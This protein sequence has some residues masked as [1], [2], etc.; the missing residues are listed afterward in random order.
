MKAEVGD[1]VA[2]RL[3]IWAVLN[4]TI[5]ATAITTD[6]K[7]ATTTVIK[8]AT[9]AGIKPARLSWDGLFTAETDN[10][11]YQCL[12]IVGVFLSLRD[13]R[14][15]GQDSM[16]KPTTTEKV[17]VEVGESANLPCLGDFRKTV[18]YW[19]YKHGGDTLKGR[20]QV[21]LVSPSLFILSIKDV[22]SSDAG[23]FT[24]S[25]QSGNDTLTLVVIEPSVP[26][27][28]RVKSVTSREVVL[29]WSAPKNNTEVKGYTIHI[30]EMTETGERGSRD[31]QIDEVSPSKKE[32]FT[33][34]GLK[35]SAE[36]EIR[37][38]AK[39]PNGVDTEQRLKNG[40]KSSCV[41]VKMKDI[42]LSDLKIQAVEAR[43]GQDN[44]I[45]IS[46]ILPFPRPAKLLGFN[47][48]FRSLRNGKSHTGEVNITSA[49]DE[50]DTESSWQAVL[51]D[52]KP[53]IK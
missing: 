34:K 25:T 31:I 14:A 51:E 41:T 6:I 52:M 27:V 53:R 18:Y 30:K 16:G 50:T 40:P 47:V 19:T 4:A 1:A 49:S 26:R 35:P 13:P 44:S 2:S 15:Y 48:T 29:A 12:F 23:N 3:L 45:V 38:S 42:P 8:P 46:W 32:M 9:T 10:M 7:P 43:E 37:L 24:C 21:S 33:V 5:A 39:Y 22:I 20:V 11:N 36:Y 28:I 17:Y